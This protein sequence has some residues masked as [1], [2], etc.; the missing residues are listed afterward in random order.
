MVVMTIE[1]LTNLFIPETVV[2]VTGYR[3]ICDVPEDSMAVMWSQLFFRHLKLW[4]TLYSLYR[5]GQ[6]DYYM[7]SLS[8]FRFA[9][10]TSPKDFDTISDLYLIAIIMDSLSISVLYL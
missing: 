9:R 4:F 8:V 6:I 5:C 10:W 2:N 3:L 7:N 1:L